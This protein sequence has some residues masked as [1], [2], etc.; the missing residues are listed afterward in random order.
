MSTSSVQQDSSL[1]FRKTPRQIRAMLN[2]SRS[3]PV[4][5]WR[6]Q[7][8]LAGGARHGLGLLTIIA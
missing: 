4:Q 8:T 7:V 2:H 6:C 5:R 3:Q 1:D